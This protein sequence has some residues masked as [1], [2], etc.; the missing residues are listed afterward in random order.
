MNFCRVGKGKSI[1]KPS[2]EQNINSN[3]KAQ[4]NCLAGG[5]QNEWFSDVIFSVVFEQ[6]G[7]S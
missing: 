5:N 2:R 1:L 6:T 3:L 7:K 4:H